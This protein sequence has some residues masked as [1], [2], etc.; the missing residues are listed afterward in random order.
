MMPT[1]I[2]NKQF[3][4]DTKKLNEAIQINIADTWLLSYQAL[5]R[6]ML[7]LFEGWCRVSYEGIIINL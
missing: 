7:L 6:G 2:S 5:G 1:Y 3:Y 4:I